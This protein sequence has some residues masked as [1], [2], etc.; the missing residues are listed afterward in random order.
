MEVPVEVPEPRILL[1]VN[2]KM[3][4]LTDE[5]AEQGDLESFYIQES[6]QKQVEWE[7]A[8]LLAKKYKGL[9]IDQKQD[10]DTCKSMLIEVTESKEKLRAEFKEMNAKIEAERED[11]KKTVEECRK[12]IAGKVTENAT[13]KA[14]VKTLRDKLEDAELRNRQLTEETR[15]LKEKLRETC[16]E[17]MGTLESAQKR[18]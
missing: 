5:S 6:P 12:Q 3:S 15:G 11:W 9:F 10:L 1:G 8:S 7:K 18:A 4:G 16:V 2:S 17:N 13:A 14:E